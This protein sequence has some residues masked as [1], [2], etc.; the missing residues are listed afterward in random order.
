VHDGAVVTE[1]VAICQYLAELYPEAGLH[2][3]PGDPLRGPYLRWLAFYGA[4]FE[5]A[6]LDRAT[7]REAPPRSMA[8]YGD[9]D[10][11]FATL[12]QQL[13]GGP[14]FLGERFTAADV[15]WGAGLN[16]TLNWKLIPDHPRVRAYVERVMARPAIQRAVQK[17]AALAEEMGLNQ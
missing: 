1:Q 2:V 11:V 16:W 14:W 6:I 7:K 5:P 12:T 8:G 13:E 9:F 17:D 3:P 10:S 15:L 4:C